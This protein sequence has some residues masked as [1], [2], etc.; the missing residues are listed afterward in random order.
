MKCRKDCGPREPGSTAPAR[1]SLRSQLDE[2]TVNIVSLD[3]QVMA[4]WKIWVP[5]KFPQ[6]YSVA[7]NNV[8]QQDKVLLIGDEAKPGSWIFW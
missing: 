6:N 2:E 3:L 4:D 1:S 7:S 5:L 8:L